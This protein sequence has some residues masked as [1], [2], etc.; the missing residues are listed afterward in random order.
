MTIQKRL[1]LLTLL[2]ML[3]C[4][5]T[6]IYANS[7]GPPS[8]N[9]GA[10]GES[11]CSTCHFG[12]AVNSGG[13]SV[14]LTG[15]PASYV[16]GTRY[17]LV[18]TISDSNNKMRWGFQTTALVDD[19]SA[20]GTFMLTD[21]TLTQIVTGQVSGK[22][23]TYVEQGFNGTQRGTRN[24]VTFKFDWVAPSTN[25]GK[26]TFYVAANAANGDG[27]LSGDSIY[28]TSAVTMADTAPAGP[29]LASLN[30][31]SGPAS[32]GTSVTLTGTNFKNGITT[33]F[34]GINATNLTIVDDKTL[35]VVT[36]AHAAGTV[37]VIVKSNDGQTARL[38][39]GFTYLSSQ[40]PAPIINSITPSTGSTAGG[41]QVTI[42]GNNFVSGLSLMIGSR[43]AMISSVT[44]TQIV[45]VTQPND[46]GPVNVVVINPDGQASVLAGA[47]TYAGG[48]QGSSLNLVAPNGGEVLSAG[49]LPFT[50]MWSQMSGATA[51]QKLELS[52]DGGSTF[53]TLLVDNLTAEK[54]S[55]VYAVPAGINTTNAKIRLSI[56]EN[57]A[58]MMDVSDA[59]FSIL[60]APVISSI[61]PT[62]TASIKLKIT[63]SNFQTG[64]TVEVNGSAVSAKVKSATSIIAKKISRSL[65]GTPIKVRVRNPNG[66][67]SM[68]MTLT[69]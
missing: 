62:V 66:T 51:T 58:T 2:L 8:S 23:R 27:S 48:Q 18:V 60:P 50:I 64:A 36:P 30:P 31:S 39:G 40:M 44:S 57:G 1:K 24:S 46:A 69:P 59:N 41:T 47:F 68:E 5:G 56:T 28:T 67:I 15:L 53:N 22:N 52:T 13:G 20:A 4:W 55:F 11:N 38:K 54:T 63:G 32:G 45:A 37:D 21:T 9:S 10:P 34:D 35:K 19:G 17:N 49:G 42:S 65:A 12:S 43:Q 6:A 3:V 16:A 33:T 29:T 7:S 14:T 61:A 26:V 25:V